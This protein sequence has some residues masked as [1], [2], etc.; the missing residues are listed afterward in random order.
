MFPGKSSDKGDKVRLS[1]LKQ[2]TATDFYPDGEPQEA[3][4]TTDSEGSP[5]WLK[6]LSKYSE[7]RR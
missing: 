3:G 7:D 2:P 5:S 1:A 4:L 6:C